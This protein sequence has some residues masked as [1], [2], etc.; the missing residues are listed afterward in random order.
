MITEES[1]H[2]QK[3]AAIRYVEEL[4]A[5]FLVAKGK[6][7]LA[8]KLI[9]IAEQ[10]NISI[11][12]QPELTESLFEFDPGTFIPEELYEIIAQLLAYIYRLQA[13]K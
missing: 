6:A 5:P 7:A 8:E 11:V 10:H 12:R 3:A 13:S 9:K 2:T 1:N 4:P